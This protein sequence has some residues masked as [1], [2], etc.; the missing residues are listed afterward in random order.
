MTQSDPVNYP[1]THSGI[2]RLSVRKNLAYNFL[3]QN[4]INIPETYTVQDGQ[5]DESALRKMLDTHPRL[6]TKPVNASLSRGLTLDIDSYDKLLDG[7]HHALANS[8]GTPSAVVQEQVRGEEIR[9]A[10][11]NGK[12]KS[13][14]LRQTPQLVGDGTSTI[15]E[16]IQAENLNRRQISV[17]YLTY[18]QL[19]SSLV[20]PLML[21]DTRIP[22][23]GETIKLSK[24]TMIKDGASMYDV[25]EDVDQSYKDKVE[26]IIEMLG[27]E[28]IAV[29]LFVIDHTAPLTVDNYAFIEFNTSP[30]LKLFYSCRDGRHFDAVSQLAHLIDRNLKK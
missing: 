17:P 16:L 2:T 7:I 24:A 10:V 25:V 19:D 27:A 13:A 12:V 1:F 28:F 9:F 20:D 30:S 11:I 15:K 14:I 22:Y 18:P 6:I 8:I 29:D 3:Q 4:G 21:Q 26:S 5:I 23:E